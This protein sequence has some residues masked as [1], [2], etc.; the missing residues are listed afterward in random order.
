MALARNR[1]SNRSVDYWPG[2]VDALSTL[3]L[4][5]M[6]LLT[7]FVIGQFILTREIS[8]KDEVLNRLNSQIAEL[9]Q[10]LALEK[11][12]NQDASDTIAALQAS[13]ASAQAERSRLQALLSEGA[14]ASDAADAR[15][16]SLSEDLEA[17][18]QLTAKAQSQLALLNQQ[19]SALRAQLAAVEEAPQRRPHPQNRS[20]TD[21][22]GLRASLC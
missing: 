19:I 5:I 15:I 13:L 12:N 9:T 20:E 7:V 11:S 8:G 6:F 3:L 18:R 17:E 1:R 2:F 21:P 22:P 10:L 16:S 14:G 4:A